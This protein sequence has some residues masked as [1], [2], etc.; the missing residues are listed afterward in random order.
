MIVFQ[1]A[2]RRHAT[3]VSGRGVGGKRGCLDRRLG[4]ASGQDVVVGNA[5]VEPTRLPN[6]KPNAG[7][8]NAEGHGEG[9]D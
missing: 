2:T 5:L 6:A 4:E 9:Y 7:G 8:S 3:I 1:R